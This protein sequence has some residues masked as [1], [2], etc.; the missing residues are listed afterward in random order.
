MTFKDLDTKGKIEHIWEYYKLKIFVVI[1]FIG[2]I[3]S[4]IYTVFIKPHPDLYCGIAMYDQFVSIED[5]K[6]LVNELNTKFNLD[7]KKYTTDIQSFYTDSTDPLTMAELN[8][9]FNTYIYNSQF[10]LLMSDKDKVEMFISAE[11]MTP[12]SDYMSQDEISALDKEEKIL[13]ALDPASGQNKPMA[14]DISDSPLL[15]KYNLYQNKNCYVGF[16]PMPDNDDR[17]TNILNAFM[18]K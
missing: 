5:T 17:T 7:P 8:Q 14:I 11:Y 2:V 15:K 10:H 13:Y 1:F 6:A 12:L 18:E 9:K 3:V 16:V 4:L